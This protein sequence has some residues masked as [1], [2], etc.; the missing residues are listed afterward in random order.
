METN[1][2]IISNPA[3]NDQREHS[4]LHQEGKILT[5]AS[6]DPLTNPSGFQATIHETKT[7]DLQPTKTPIVHRISQ[8]L[9]I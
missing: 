9:L 8:A 7:F 4:T 5:I 2:G 1:P 3:G 6:T